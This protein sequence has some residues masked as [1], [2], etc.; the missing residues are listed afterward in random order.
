MVGI[1]K[2]LWPELGLV[3]AV[4]TGAFAHYATIIQSTYFKGDITTKE[5]IK[6]SRALK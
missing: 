5:D 3:N 4:T 1:A 2:R 6:Y